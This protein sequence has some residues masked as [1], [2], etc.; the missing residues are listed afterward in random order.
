MHHRE[1]RTSEKNIQ[2]G[3]YLS[4]LASA[5]ARQSGRAQTAWNR[6]IFHV[7]VRRREHA[8]TPWRWEIWAAAQTMAVNQSKTHYLTMSQAMKEDKVL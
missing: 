2:R 4:F 5:F 6:A 7:A 3:D 1:R 8:A